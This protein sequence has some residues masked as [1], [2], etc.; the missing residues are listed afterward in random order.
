MENASRALIIAGG[1]LISIIILTALVLLFNQLGGAYSEE[2]ASLTI[3][4][5]EEYNRRF[6][7]YNVTD[8]LYGSELLSLANLIVDY[9]NRLL[10]NE[11]PDSD[12]YRENKINVYV[13]ITRPITAA[14][15]NDGNMI[16]EGLPAR[17][18]MSVE[19]IK[20]YNDGIS[21]RISEMEANGWNRNSSDH[22]T[23]YTNLK[24]LLTELRSMVFRCDTTRTT[25]NS[26]GRIS[27]MYFEQV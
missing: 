14:Y 26:Y 19:Y 24:S 13:T 3:E 10:Y 20:N 17:S 11:N 22:Y 23:D 15:D 27:T 16:Y 25:Y 2:S 8:G 7:I 21:A 6:N 5:I 1:I 18:N 9:D 4:Q 12:F